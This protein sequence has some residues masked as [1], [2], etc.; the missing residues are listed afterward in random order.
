V[1][2]TSVNDRGVLTARG[3]ITPAETAPARP[4][5]QRRDEADDADDKKDDAGDL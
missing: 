5:D 2:G 3:G 1:C 4:K